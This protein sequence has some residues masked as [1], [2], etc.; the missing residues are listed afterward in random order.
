MQISSTSTDVTI[1]LNIVQSYEDQLGKTYM[2]EFVGNCLSEIDTNIKEILE[3][4]D[5]EN[6]DEARFVTHQTKNFT[7]MLGMT[8]LYA[9]TLKIN[10]AL[11][12]NDYGIAQTL[13]ADLHQC[14]SD[15]LSAFKASF[16]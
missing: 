12:Q 5:D 3:F 14:Y 1:D 4:M 11:D 16:F 9:L 13:C 15:N 10:R 6:Y 7:A 8:S 2:K